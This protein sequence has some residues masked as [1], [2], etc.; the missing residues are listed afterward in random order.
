M[1]IAEMKQKIN[2]KVDELDEAQ[3]QIVIDVIE[4]IDNVKAEIPSDIASI[5]EE[6]VARYGNVLQKLAQ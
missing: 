2:K 1:S 5:F 6:A 4:K 3:L